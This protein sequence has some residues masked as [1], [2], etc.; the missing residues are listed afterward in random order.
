MPTSSVSV[1]GKTHC[2]SS[3]NMPTLAFTLASM[4]SVIHHNKGVDLAALSQYDATEQHYLKALA[5][6]NKFM[7]KDAISTALTHNTLGQLYIATNGLDEHQE[8]RA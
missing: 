3:R 1:N 8:M 6:K 5:I 7:G 4:Q 2:M